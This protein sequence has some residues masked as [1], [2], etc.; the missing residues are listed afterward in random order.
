MALIILIC[1][2]N[3]IGMLDL[4]TNLQQN[5][6]EIRYSTYIMNNCKFKN[7]LY[8][9]DELCFHP[10]ETVSL[11]LENSSASSRISNMNANS[12]E[13]LSRF[14]TV[15]KKLSEV[16]IVLYSL[17]KKECSKIHSDLPA[18]V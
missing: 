13:S 14:S 11:P 15:K 5:V 18:V 6:R 3:E 17:F 2:L 1:I 10:V 12:Q 4:F 16:C 7:K 8:I 9:K